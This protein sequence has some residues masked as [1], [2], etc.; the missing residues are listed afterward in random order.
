VENVESVE[1]QIIMDGME[2][3]SDPSGQLEI[4]QVQP[5]DG[6]SMPAYPH[7]GERE[8][9]DIPFLRISRPGDAHVNDPSGVLHS[10][11]PIMASECSMDGLIFCFDNTRCGRLDGLSGAGRSLGIYWSGM[12]PATNR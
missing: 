6:V 10:S 8:V 2:F 4:G 12:A 3:R 11:F 9:Y 5:L 7:V 1:P